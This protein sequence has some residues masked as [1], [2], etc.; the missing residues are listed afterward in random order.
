MPLAGVVG[1]TLLYTGTS[2]CLSY[3]VVFQNSGRGSNL[4]S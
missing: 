4:V 3:L 1:D 2:T